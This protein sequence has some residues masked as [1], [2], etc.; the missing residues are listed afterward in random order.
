MINKYEQKPSVLDVIL[1]GAIILFLLYYVECENWILSYLG[2]PTIIEWLLSGI[3]WIWSTNK[4]K[5]Y[6]H[7]Y[8]SMTEKNL[9]PDVYQFSVR[10]LLLKKR[11]WI[12]THTYSAYL[13]IIST[14]VITVGFFVAH[15]SLN[16]LDAVFA[17]ATPLMGALF[18]IKGGIELFNHYRAEKRRID[19]DDR[20]KG[21]QR[22]SSL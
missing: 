21:W 16:E 3:L 17:F 9:E 12:L 18:V 13:F 7:E 19:E 15:S 1:V 11:K 6:H 22:R 8:Q 4:L 20:H 5:H 14:F 2:T 10:N